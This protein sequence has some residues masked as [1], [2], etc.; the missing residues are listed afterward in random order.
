MHICALMGALHSPLKPYTV[1]KMHLLGQGADHALLSSPTEVGT[2]E[3]LLVLYASD[4]N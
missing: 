2:T 1:I 4:V 3:F